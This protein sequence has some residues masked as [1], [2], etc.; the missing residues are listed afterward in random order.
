MSLEKVIN[1]INKEAADKAREILSEAKSKSDS[2]IKEAELNAKENSTK[3]M[4]ELSIMIENL[5]SMKKAGIK[6]EANEIIK[7]RKKEA[8]DDSMR[9]INKAAH[10][11]TLTDFYPGLLQ[12]LVDASIKTLGQDAL[13]YIN[14]EDLEKIKKK[15]K[16]VLVSK[17]RML[18]GV[19]AQSAD[20][21]MSL[22]YSLDS[23]IEELN[24][25]ITQEVLSAIGK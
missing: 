8:F 3:E 13:I 25:V 24:D 17:N 1:K 14:K 16:Q 19:Y 11:L 4:K 15:P 22:D 10:A 23:I 20:G 9:K 21:K 12:K 2:I 5:S 18:G 6:V 7:K